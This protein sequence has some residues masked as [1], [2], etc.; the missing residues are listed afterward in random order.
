MIVA[1]EHAETQCHCSGKCVEKGFLLDG[2][3]LET[4][5]IAMGYHQGAVDV[6]T[7]FAYPFAT[8]RDFTSVSARRAEHPLF[9]EGSVELSRYGVPVEGLAERFHDSKV[10]FSALGVKR[11]I[12]LRMVLG[13]CCVGTYLRQPGVRA[14]RNPHSLERD[15]PIRSGGTTHR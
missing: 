8:R 14:K 4:G 11:T 13:G 6:E 7:D 15:V 12:R 10:A 9:F 5:D 3:N 2:V 1:P